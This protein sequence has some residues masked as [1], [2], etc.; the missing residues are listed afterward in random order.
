MKR[1]H[2]HGEDRRSTQENIRYDPK[3][4]RARYAKKSQKS[5]P[6]KTM[7]LSRHM[8]HRK[9]EVNDYGIDARSDQ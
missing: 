9:W 6:G 1:L 4:H 7:T 8:T 5:S 2:V 3:S